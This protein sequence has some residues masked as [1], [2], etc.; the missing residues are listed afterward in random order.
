MQE[1]T[2]KELR[3]ALEGVPDELPVRNGRKI[4]Q[5]VIAY[6]SHSYPEPYCQEN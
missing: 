5:D 6:K 3:E 4:L 2:V 1:L